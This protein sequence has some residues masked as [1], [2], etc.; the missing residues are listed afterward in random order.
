MGVHLV[1]FGIVSGGSMVECVDGCFF[2]TIM[3]EFKSGSTILIRKI[4]T[5]RR[6]RCL[7]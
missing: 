7:A 1:N 3:D 4:G 6:V 2:E 5:L